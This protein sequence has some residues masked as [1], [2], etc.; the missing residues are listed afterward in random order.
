MMGGYTGHPIG[1]QIDLDEMSC[2]ITTMS[3]PHGNYDYR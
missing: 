2:N 1:Q 3:P